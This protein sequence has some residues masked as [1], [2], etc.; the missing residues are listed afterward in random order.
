M[1]A[2]RFAVF[3]SHMSTELA[4]ANSARCPI[5]GCA[6]ND[7][8]AWDADIIGSDQSEKDDLS[9][10]KDRTCKFVRMHSVHH[11]APDVRFSTGQESDRRCLKGYTHGLKSTKVAHQ[12]P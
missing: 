7:K 2:L 4:L 5:D 8:A 1:Y 10:L 9:L 12:R 3:H 6:I 11:H